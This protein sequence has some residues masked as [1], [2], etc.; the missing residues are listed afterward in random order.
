MVLL[1]RD[2]VVLLVD[3]V[4]D[5]EVSLSAEM[6]LVALIANVADKSGGLSVRLLCAS[7][8]IQVRNYGFR[9]N[10]TGIRYTVAIRNTRI[11]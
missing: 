9:T 3:S 10:N 8:R 6:L 7:H 11:R 5:S 2:G 1:L 4:L